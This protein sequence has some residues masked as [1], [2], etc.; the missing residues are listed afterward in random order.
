MSK[1]DA[2]HASD[3]GGLCDGCGYIATDGFWYAGPTPE[4]LKELQQVYAEG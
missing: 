3:C 1:R 4:H 2:W